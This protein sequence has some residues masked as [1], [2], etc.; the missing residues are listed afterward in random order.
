MSLFKKSPQ[1][2]VKKVSMELT[3]NYLYNHLLITWVKDHPN[4]KDTTQLMQIFDHMLTDQ[5]SWKKMRSNFEEDFVRV[6]LI[7]ATDNV[8]KTIK[9]KNMTYDELLNKI[10]EK[11]GY[12]TFDLKTGKK[13]K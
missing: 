8:K 12:S 9:E 10:A 13:I 4:E 11:F 5:K 1:D 3:H 6:C 7:E 2:I